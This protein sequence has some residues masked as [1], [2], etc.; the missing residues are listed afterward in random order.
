[1]VKT[2]AEVTKASKLWDKIKDIPLEIF[3]LPNQ[4]VKDHIKREEAM[5][6]I[7]P[8]DV[9]VTLRSQAVLPALENALCNVK[10]GKN[11]KIDI[12]QSNRYTVIKIVPK[13]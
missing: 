3:A 1:M 10:L 9:Y 2:Q 5:E 12:S 6:A 13:V 4:T 8:N 7:F 11:E